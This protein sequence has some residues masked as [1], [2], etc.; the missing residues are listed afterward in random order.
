[1][2][3]TQQGR[4]RGWNSRSVASRF[5]HAFFYRL[6][7]LGGR[8]WAYGF[9]RLVVLW[10]TLFRPALRD[11]TLFYLRRRFPEARGAALLHHSYKLSV[12]FGK[13]LVDRAAVGILGPDELGASFTTGRDALLDLLAEGK[14][15]ILMGAHVGGWQAAMAAM[16]FLETP[17]NMLMQRDAGD[18]DRHWF[19]HRGME[20]PFKVIDP[21]GY[22]GGAVEMHAALGRG[23]VLCVMGDRVQGS[24]RNVLS[25]PFLGEQA[26]FPVSAYRVAA[27]TGA[28]VAVFFSHRTAAGGYELEVPEIIR[29]PRRLGRGAEGCR[30]YVMRFAAALESY[31]HRYPYQFYNFHNMWR[32]EDQE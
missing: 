12:Q 11:R 6:I 8:P 22:L 25:V 13:A 26:S 23:E 27:A 18:V 7:R 21:S 20:T 32:N 10:Y 3:E 4:P 14:G 15:C 24:E 29:V 28:P 16:D 30:P 5:Q 9:L 1:M 31:C 19:E 2:A 17:V